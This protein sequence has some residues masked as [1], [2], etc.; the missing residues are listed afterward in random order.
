MFWRGLREQQLKN[1]CR[2][3]KDEVTTFDNLVRLVRMGERELVAK[4]PTKDLPTGPPH[5]TT[6][7]DFKNALSTITSSLAELKVALTATPA[8][9]PIPPPPSFHSFPINSNIPPPPAPFECYKCSQVGHIARGWRNPPKQPKSMH[10]NKHLPQ[11]GGDVAGSSTDNPIGPHN[12]PPVLTRLVGNAN[13]T[14]ACVS[15]VRCLCL[16][17][18]GSQVTSLS[19]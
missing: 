1:I 15:G 2:H 10:L 18:T 12:T 16:V 5:P 11:Q 14:E 19:Q 4:R 6:N 3:K 13:E 7:P 9:P 17:D 8:L